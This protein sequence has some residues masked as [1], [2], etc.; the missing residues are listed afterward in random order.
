MFWCLVGTA[1]CPGWRAPVRA[2]HTA[3]NLCRLHAWFG[4]ARI[5]AAGVRAPRHRRRPPPVSQYLC[6]TQKCAQSRCRGFFCCAAKHC[7]TNSIKS[8]VNAAG[9]NGRLGFAGGFP[10]AGS[11]H[12]ADGLIGIPAGN[13]ARRFSVRC[14]VYRPYC[15]CSTRK[16]LQSFCRCAKCFFPPCWSAW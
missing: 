3:P 8:A 13:S 9:R 16:C 7:C 11:L 14:P 5:G 6:P 15:V 2:K 4:K 10:C 12:F 1:N